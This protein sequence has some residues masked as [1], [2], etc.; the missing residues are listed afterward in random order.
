[1]RAENGST[2]DFSYFFERAIPWPEHPQYGAFHSGDM[3]YTFDN[4]KLMDRPWEPVDHTLA[5]VASSYWVNFVATGNP[6]GKD[7]PRWPE[8][9]NQHMLLGAEVQPE[10]ILSPKKLRFFLKTFSDDSMNN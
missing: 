10:V 7:L 8:D 9:N 4:L 2:P 1:V 5:D 3:P 6:N